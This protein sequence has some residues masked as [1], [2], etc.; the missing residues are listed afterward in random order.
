VSNYRGSFPQQVR[1]DQFDARM[2]HYLSAKNTAYV[3]YSYKRLKPRMID[4]G[5]PP[6]FAGLSD[7]RAHRSL[8]RAFGYLDGHTETHQ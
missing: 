6:E 5:L 4:S 3:R 1:Q 7:Q 2:D 8:D